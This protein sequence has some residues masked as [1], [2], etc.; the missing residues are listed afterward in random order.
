LQSLIKRLQD[1]QDNFLRAEAE[2]ENIR[3]RAVDDVAK[4]REFAIENFAQ[5]LVPVTDSLYAALSTDVGDAKAFKEGL[6]ITLKQLL[7]AFEKGKMTEIDPAVGQQFHPHHHQAIAS[8]P[9]EQEPNTVVSVISGATPLADRVLRPALVT[10]RCSKIS[11]KPEKSHKKGRFL[12][13][14]LFQPLN[15]DELTPFKNYWNIRGNSGSFTEL[16]LTLKQL[17]STTK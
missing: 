6:E 1:L 9:S 3:R 5:H 17:R 4:A 13:F 12:P 10:V 16:P 14:L 7:S 15:L 8:V 2:G 11:K